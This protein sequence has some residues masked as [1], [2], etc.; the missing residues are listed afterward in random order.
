M[1]PA[2]WDLPPAVFNLEICQ[3]GSYVPHGIL[4]SHFDKNGLGQ[5]KILKLW[6]TLLISSKPSWASPFLS[7]SPS[8]CFSCSTALL[9]CIRKRTNSTN[10]GWI[11]QQ[12]NIC[13]ALK[14]ALQSLS[15]LCERPD[16]KTTHKHVVWN[17]SHFAC[18]LQASKHT[19]FIFNI[20][21]C[22]GSTCINYM[23]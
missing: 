22:F 23:R 11:D 10:E 19:F 6:T 20:D 2:G 21:C 5:T 4:N 12:K 3:S 16:T 8:S 9:F 15:I 18:L 14:C 17:D 13:R 7:C 1:V